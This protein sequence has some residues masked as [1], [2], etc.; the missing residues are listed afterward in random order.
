MDWGLNCKV[1][2][3]KCSFQHSLCIG[4][5]GGGGNVVKLTVVTLKTFFSPCHAID[6]PWE[7]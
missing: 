5:K 1:K 2:S 4:E 3:S 7:S 6:F